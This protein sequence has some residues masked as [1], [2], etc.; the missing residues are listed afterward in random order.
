[1]VTQTRDTL[2]QVVDGGAGL[3]PLA[4]MLAVFGG[5]PLAAE[6][7]VGLLGWT[8]AAILAGLSL[9]VAIRRAQQLS[10]V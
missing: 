6:A 9:L 3:I 10:L 2:R 7:G 8:F 5:I 4:T 1:M